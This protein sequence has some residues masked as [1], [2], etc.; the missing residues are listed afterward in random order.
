VEDGE[1]EVEG[2][3]NEVNDDDGKRRRER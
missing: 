2:D 1:D 3:V